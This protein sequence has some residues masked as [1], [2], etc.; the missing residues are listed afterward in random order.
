MKAF[1]NEREAVGN[2]TVN[3]A[4]GIVPVALPTHHYRLLPTSNVF[5]HAGQVSPKSRQE[6]FGQRPA[7]IWLTGLSGAGKSTLAYELEKKLLS[8]GHPCF[9]LDG[10]NMR[11]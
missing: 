10:D 8:E 5:W 11:H 2:S 4:R 7:T 9:V 3:V 1:G 6:Y